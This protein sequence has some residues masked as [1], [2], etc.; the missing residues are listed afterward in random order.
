LWSSFPGNQFTGEIVPALTALVESGTIRVIDILFVNKDADGRA[1]IVELKDLGMD[2]ASFDSAL[3][4]VTD[5]LTEEDVEQFGAMLEPNSS[6]AAMLFEN[7][8]ATRF[9]DAVRAARGELLLNERIPRV[10]IE[11]LMR[12][13]AAA[14]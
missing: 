1:E 9:A 10:V 2:V 8:W 12:T 14:V 6:A 11:E 13:A 4:D 7:T 5:L 3:S